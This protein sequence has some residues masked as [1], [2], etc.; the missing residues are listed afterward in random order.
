MNTDVG[1]GNRQR[2]ESFD[3]LKFFGALA[4]VIGH[5]SALFPNGNQVPILQDGLLGIIARYGGGAVALF[6][7]ISGYTTMSNYYS[8]IGQRGIKSYLLP[9]I[10]RLWPLHFSTMLFCFVLQQIRLV[11]GMEYYIY[12]AN[13]LT[14]VIV[15]SFF[16]GHLVTPELS[17]NG[18]AWTMSVT[19]FCYIAFWVVMKLDDKVNHN[20]VFAGLAIF[21][22]YDLY[23]VLSGLGSGFPYIVDSVQYAA[24]FFIGCLMFEI[25]RK[26]S[27]NMKLKNTLDKVC[28]C[29]ILGL[30][31][32]FLFNNE[33]MKLF[34]VDGFEIFCIYILVPL[35]M[36][37]FG[38]VKINAFFAKI[39][40][41]FRIA[42][43]LFFPIYLIHFP[44]ML[45]IRTLEEMKIIY[46]DYS[47]LSF[48]VAWLV[49][50][51]VSAGIVA[52]LQKK[53]QEKWS[54]LIK[55]TKGL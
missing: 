35:L 21:F 30:I 4:I 46:V 24:S 51:L 53:R 16:G 15:G 20:Y 44:L 52:F 49:I 10:L 14:D 8:Q 33:K 13:S 45:L 18:P 5:Y 17:L 6:L 37:L 54:R 1:N 7:Q 41:K 50:V 55:E 25:Y 38:G 28:V 29:I 27:D 31:L 23:M 26:A 39:P 34:G 2:I 48:F 43:K 3:W 32:L 9:K 42:S 19:F 11:C 22:T 40:P 47:T 36:Y 12:Q